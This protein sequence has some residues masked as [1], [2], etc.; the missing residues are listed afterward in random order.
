Q[1]LSPKPFSRSLKTALTMVTIG[2]FV[3][4]IVHL[5]TEPGTSS[6]LIDF[7]GNQH[8]PST[9]RFMLLDSAVY[10]VQALRVLISSHLS[11]LLVPVSANTVSSAV[12]TS[13]TAIIDTGRHSMENTRG[14]LF[15][16]PGVV[17][18]IGLRSSLRNA[19]YADMEDSRSARDGS[20]QLPV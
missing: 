5:L 20:D 3:C 11:Q 8:K 18:D 6:I 17:V 14:D 16:Y 19:L 7:I 1:L 9:L 4:S 12:S 2:Y 13:T 15:Y 10:I